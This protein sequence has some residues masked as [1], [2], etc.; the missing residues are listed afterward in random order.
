M[1][2]ELCRA[3]G[4]AIIADKLSYFIRTGQ[5]VQ[6]FQSQGFRIN[7]V[8]LAKYS[9]SPNSA[10]PPPEAGVATAEAGQRPSTPLFYSR[11]GR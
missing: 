6:L 8:Q 11:K 2:G 7:Y 1:T 9:P 10:T 3:Q 4:P 5:M